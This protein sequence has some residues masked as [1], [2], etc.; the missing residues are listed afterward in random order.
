MYLISERNGLFLSQEKQFNQ[1]LSLAGLTREHVCMS[2]DVT[3][4]SLRALGLG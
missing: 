1:A 3:R 2:S 4:G